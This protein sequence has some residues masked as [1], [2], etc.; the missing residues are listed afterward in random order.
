MSATRQ[1]MHMGVFVLGTGN[2]SA[3]WRHEGAATS[4]LQLPIIQE[5]ARIAERGKFDLL[6]R[7][8]IPPGAAT[9]VLVCPGPAP[10][11]I[12]DST[13]LVASPVRL[14]NTRLTVDLCPSGIAAIAFDGRPVLAPQGI[15]PHLR[16]DH[17][18]TW[19]TG[20]DRWTEPV[21]AALAGGTWEVEE[22]GLLRASMRM[23]HRIGTSRLRWTLSL[24]RDD[25]RLFMRLE[26]NFDERLTLL[27]L[28]IHLVDGPIRRTDAVPGG[29]VRR[30]NS[31]VEYP[32]QG[33]SRLSCA[34]LEMALVT[35][36]AYSL[37]VD[38][39]S[40]QWTLL[41][42]PR[43]AWPGGDPPIYHRHN[44]YTDQGVHDLRFELHF[45]E[46]LP[47]STLD[48]AARRMAQPP[49]AFDRTERLRRPL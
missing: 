45:G 44:T 5:I 38:G 32:V 35:Q 12:D 43:M 24:L 37:S 34:D 1:Q 46:T 36:D 18:D 28:G 49:I 26:V 40:W 42:S 19:G 29:A 2:H 15:V 7:T 41:R 21:Y 3:G 25:P 11:T 14:A 16:D 6:F 17:T 10:P 47:D 31:P 20:T 39:G 23:K 13:G 48:I 30:P 33:W 8:V 4:N 27:Q 22:T 9:T